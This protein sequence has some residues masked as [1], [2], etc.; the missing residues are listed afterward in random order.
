M[1]EMTRVREMR[2][3][4]G[5]TQNFKQKPKKKKKTLKEKRF[6][7]KNSFFTSRAELKQ[8]G[9]LSRSNPAWL[10]GWLISRY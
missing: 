5:G 8:P 10:I 1:S 7:K 3:T 4:S 6:K 2:P 9:L